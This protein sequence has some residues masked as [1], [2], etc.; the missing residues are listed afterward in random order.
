MI[1]IRCPEWDLIQPNPFGISRTWMHSYWCGASRTKVQ[2]PSLFRGIFYS[3][4]NN[5]KCPER[6][7]T[8]SQS[9]I[10]SAFLSFD[11]SSE[12]NV[13]LTRFAAQRTSNRRL[14]VAVRGPGFK[15]LVTIGAPFN[16]NLVKNR[17]PE[18]DLN[19]R[20][21]LRRLSGYPSYPTGAKIT[22]AGIA[23]K[24]RIIKII[25]PNGLIL[26]DR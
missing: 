12:S 5:I 6:D 21:K 24:W 18:W 2:I 9:R 13:H 8:S 11:T 17:C 3:F 7:L 10:V 22:I 23:L 25:W 20:Q 15:S 1:L 4:S 14:G 16:I 26:N 19:P